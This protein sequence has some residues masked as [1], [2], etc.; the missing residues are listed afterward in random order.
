MADFGRIITAM[1][2]PFKQDGSLDLEGVKTLARNLMQS[3]SDSLV[4]GGTTGE[5]PTLTR[6][7]KLALFRASKEAVGERCMILAGTGSNTTSASVELTREAEQ[8]GVDGI[9]LVVPYYNK[10]SQEGLYRHFAACAGA[11]QLPVMLY[12]IPGRTGINLLPETVARLAQVKNIVALKEAS[13]S[14][15]QM[16]EIRRLVPDDFRL[17][18]GDDSLT[19]PLVSVGAYGVVSVASHLVGEQLQQMVADLVGGSYIQARDTHLRLFP[20]FKALFLAPNPVPIKAALKHLGL[21]SGP[22]RLPLVELTK[23][24]EDRLLGAMRDVGIM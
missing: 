14:M 6:E 10:P 5:S 21:P 9:M 4:I 2:T 13:G 20:L 12:N 8:C 23:K 3:G 24:E 22:P 1:I 11:T 17:Y 7:E 15:D 16:S 18:S 19:L